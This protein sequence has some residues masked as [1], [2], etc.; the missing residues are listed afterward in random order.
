VPQ[1]DLDVDRVK[2]KSLGVSLSS[3]YET[4]QVYLGSLYV[5][6]FNQFGRTY[7]VVA[8]ADSKFRDG[9]DDIR[10]LKVRNERGQMVPIGTL[11]T[12]REAFG[13]D[14]VMRYNG[15]P[16]AEI[17]GAPAPGYSSGQA[18]AAME[19]LAA[20]KLPEGYGYEWSGISL[21]EKQS[22]GQAPVIFGL[23]LLFVFLF[24][25]ALYESWTVPL[26]VLF[27]I[28]LGVFG[29]MLG[30]YLTGLTNN[31]YSQ[32]GLVLLI[33]LAAKNAILI[34]EFAKMLREQGQD[35]VSAALG[36]A[37]LR[38]RPIMMTSFAF[39]L[40]VVPLILA[41]GAGAASRVSMG[42]TVFSGMLAA[43]LLAIFL[44]PVLYVVVDRLF[45]R[46]DAPTQP[47][48]PPASPAA[49]ASETTS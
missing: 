22:A 24:L 49:H 8:Q 42:I 6:D 7:Q 10:R 17:N 12:V 23:A 31:I 15:Y 46:R 2:A 29:A 3:L 25:A 18:L 45:G 47:P 16:A 4:L 36:A 43:T 41:S 40:G 11:V 19:R 9:A 26:A 48:A 34:V 27:A 44:V 30:L 39:I 1:I 5:N 33:G 21:Q 32:I 28:P 14:R 20:E 37:R 13:P 38:L 35:A